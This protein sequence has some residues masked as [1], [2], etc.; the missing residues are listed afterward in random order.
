MESDYIRLWELAKKTPT[1][2]TH[3]SLVHVLGGLLVES[4]EVLSRVSPSRREYMLREKPTAIQAPPDSIREQTFSMLLDGLASGVYTLLA[5]GLSFPPD[6]IT[7]LL[8]DFPLHTSSI[9]NTR[10]SPMPGINESAF[11]FGW[12]R[13]FVCL[14]YGDS[15]LDS[16]HV[17][18]SGAPRLWLVIDRS[19]VYELETKISDV[20]DSASLKISRAWRCGSC[21]SPLKHRRLM[22]TPNQLSS[23]GIP[24]N[25]FVQ[26]LGDVVYL[27]VGVP[28]QAID[29]GYN[30]IELLQPGSPEWNVFGDYVAPCSCAETKYRRVACNRGAMADTC[31][32]GA[33]FYRCEYLDCGALFKCPRQL[34]HHR[35]CHSKGVTVVPV[36]DAAA[37]RGSV[38]SLEKEVAALSGEEPVVPFA[39]GADTLEEEA[40]NAPVKRN[41]VVSPKKI[42]Y[43]S[44]TGAADSFAPEEVILPRPS[45]SR[46][47]R[48]SPQFRLTTR[49]HQDL[50]PAFECAHCR[51]SYTTRRSLIRHLLDCGQPPKPCSSCG[52]ML[53]FRGRSKHKCPKDE[54]VECK[55]GRRL[56]TKTAK[57]SHWDNKCLSVSSF[58][59]FFANIGDSFFYLD[60]SLFSRIR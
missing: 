46:A 15:H 7:P 27:P 20:L 23:W 40:D 54:D 26:K 47:G 38:D 39:E 55:C 56:K 24:F 9:L 1:N 33:P 28:Y 60:D 43:A 36:E 41:I 50:L 10:L 25:I 22:V 49:P 17:L 31:P 5:D 53:K 14:R 16:I 6:L 12:P 45:T 30:A 19:Y 18:V 42:S 51:S 3:L 2:V 35:S 29:L 48:P 44:A 21:P 11:S 37:M 59:Y 32:E 8:A 34:V 52:R 57:R 13:S 58:N 4:A